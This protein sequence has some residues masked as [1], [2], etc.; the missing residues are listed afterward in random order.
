MSALTRR[1]SRGFLPDLLDWAG[2][3]LSMLR[4][5]FMQSIRI[6]DY[7]ENGRYVVRAELPG[8]DPEKQ[9]EITVAHGA[10][11]IRAAREEEH[12]GTYR[13][14]FR[15]GAFSRQ[16]A[17]PAAADEDDVRAAYRNG[18]LEISI[19]LKEKPPGAARQIPVRRTG[20]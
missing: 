6:E 17:L 16:V 19:G 2:S 4:P 8:I 1:E 15:Y 9:A 11:T 14:E 20:K 3:P 12:E 13:T 18:V 10:L 7:V 5:F